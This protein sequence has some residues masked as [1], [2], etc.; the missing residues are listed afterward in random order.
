MPYGKAIG[1]VR[2]EVEQHGGHALPGM[3][4]VGGME[5]W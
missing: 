1:K 2:S 5:T 4:D 3:A